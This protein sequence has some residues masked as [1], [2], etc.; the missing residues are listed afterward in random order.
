MR[1]YIA[2]FIGGGFG[3]VARFAVSAAT[4]RYGFFGIPL[5]TFLVNVTGSL[6]LGFGLSLFESVLVPVPFRTFVTVGFFG[7]YTTFST[8]T[9][10]TVRLIEQRQYLPA[11]LNFSLN[12][13]IGFAAVLAGFVLSGLLQKV[14]RGGV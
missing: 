4:S 9:V 5:G 7:A 8:Y 13:I 3:A 2:V 1:N 10:E 6:L 11:F 12:N 14:L